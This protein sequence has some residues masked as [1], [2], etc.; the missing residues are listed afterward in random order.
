CWDDS[1]ST[2]A[3]AAAV[4]RHGL[5]IMLGPPDLDAGDEVPAA[6]GTTAPLFAHHSTSRP[7]PQRPRRT[8]RLESGHPDCQRRNTTMKAPITLAVLASCAAATAAAQCP[9]S[10]FARGN[11]LQAWQDPGLPAV[12][13]R[14]ENPPRPFSLGGGQASDGPPPAPPSAPPSTAIP[15]V[16]AAG[17]TWEVVWSWEG[18]NAD[19]LIADRDGSM[20]FANNDASNVMRLDPATGLATVIH[21]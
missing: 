18:N 5:P 2:S 12:L 20:L 13:A 1:S 10:A 4:D 16:I 14:C 15:D 19:G 21:D 9:S 7:Q 11:S 6:T 8:F 17:Q 3:N